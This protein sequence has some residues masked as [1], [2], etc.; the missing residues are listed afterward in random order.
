MLVQGI[1]EKTFQ[2]LKPYLATSGE[3]TLQGEG[4]RQP[5]QLLQVQV[6][7]GRQ[8]GRQARRQAGPRQGR[9][10]AGA[11][12]LKRAGR[13]GAWRSASPV[14]L[15][16]AR[17][18]R[19]PTKTLSPNGFQLAELTI[20]LAILAF[21][22]M[23]GAPDLLRGSG[24]LRLRLAA[25]EL[26]SVLR[27]ARSWAVR[28]DANVA[29]KFRTAA[30]GT[31]TFTLYRDGNGNGVLTADI[32]SGKDPQVEP[33]R[34]LSN[35]GRGVGFGFPP[36]PPPT[37]PGSPGHLLTPSRSDP[38]QQLGPR[39]VQPAGHLDARLALPDGRPPT[40]RRGAPRE[41]RG[42][43]AGPHLRRR[44]AGLA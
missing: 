25:D 28:H 37:D 17:A 39:L 33:P 6:Q 16:E 40:A 31:V 9:S 22:M 41:P 14:P 21:M 2:L 27:L 34:R 7:V 19:L 4:A 43:G 35:F 15:R 23:L 10:A 42:H 29:V 44:E 13:G 11:L 20:V 12:P 38:L 36:G 18:M 3:T 8:V 32:D 30:D 24:D 5:L 1:G 26:V